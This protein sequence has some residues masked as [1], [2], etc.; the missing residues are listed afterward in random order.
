MGWNVNVVMWNEV[1]CE[2]WHGMGNVVRF[3]MR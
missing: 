2:L 1:E 3:G